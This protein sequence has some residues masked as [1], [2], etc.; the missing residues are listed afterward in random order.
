VTSANDPTAH[1]EV[2]AI[3][4]A[5]ASLGSFSL[6]GC[7][8]Y[9][10]CEPCPMCLAAA[11]WAR[12]DA[13]VYGA[14]RADAAAA[15]F[16]DAVVFREVGRPPEERMVQGRRVL[17]GEAAAALREWLEIPDRIPY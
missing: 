17:G 15:G 3:R 2:V 11:H 9:A 13:L 16:D 12:L 5:C 7:T 8:L 6:Q 10:S 4:A 1:A 14:T